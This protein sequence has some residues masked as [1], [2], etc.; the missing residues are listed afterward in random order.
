[1]PKLIL[2]TQHGNFE[3]AIKNEGGNTL[4]VLRRNG[5]PSSMVSIVL[6]REGNDNYLPS[7]ITTKFSDLK[8]NDEVLVRIIRNIDIRNFSA[9]LNVQKNDNFSTEWIESVEKSD[10]NISNFLI[11]LDQKRAAGIV[12]DAV[13]YFFKEFPEFGK[14]KMIVGASGGGDSNALL[15]ALKE[16]IPPENIVVVTLIGFPDWT[17]ASARRATIL[18]E[19]YGFQQITVTPEEVSRNCGF[20][21]SLQE[22]IQSFKSTFG[23]EEL[24]FL[25]T[26]A[27]QQNLIAKAQELN[28]SDI[29][30]GANREDMLGESLYYISRGLLP[31]PFPIRPF[32]KY[33][34]GFPLWLV[35]KKIID[36]VHPK[37]S[38]ENYEE[39]DPGST[40][41]RDR[42]YFLA[43]LLEDSNIGGDLLTLKGLSKISQNNKNW[44]TTSDELNIPLTNAATDIGKKNWMNWLKTVTD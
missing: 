13:S 19:K 15:T 3:L 7:S 22:A 34:F 8:H 23:P 36:G 11:Q 39:R 40:R 35:P 26:F 16:S 30:L 41:W 12:I 44:L 5:I 25:S 31:S 27:I 32:N 29:I 2:L 37:M 38:V 1:M 21:V 10:G 20:K 9:K 33:R 42:F 4:D 28:S 24:I 18:C 17:E 43:H 14:N 6:K